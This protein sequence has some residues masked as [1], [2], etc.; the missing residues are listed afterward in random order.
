[1]AEPVPLKY[2]AFISYSHADTNWAK[3][4]QRGLEAFKIDKDLAGRE[5]ARGAIPESLRPIFRDREDFTAGEALPEQTLAALD[6]SSA[7][8]VVCSPDSNHSH[9]VNEE[10]RAFKSRHPSRS[11]IPLIVAG[12]PD[13]PM[14]ECFPPPLKFKFDTKG[15]VT[16]EKS[17]L[18]AADARDE[19]DGKDLALAKVIAGLLG[20]SPDEVFRRAERERRAAIRRRRRV[21]IGF[22]A[23]GWLL[24]AGL[25]A[26]INQNY[27]MEQW[28]WFS[29]IRPY[30]LSQFRPHVLTAEAEQALKP[31]DTFRECAKDCPE[32]VVLPAGMFVMGSPLDEKG[33]HESE[34]PQHEVTISKPFAVSKFEVTF[35]NWEACVSYG[36]CPVVGDSG[37]GRGQQPVI[38]LSWA[39]AQHYVAWLVRMTGK[40][41]R[42]LSE[43]EWEYA[44]RAG[45]QT[46]YSWG[47]ELGEGNANCKGCGSQWDDQQTAPVG[48]FA[49]NAFGLHDLHGNVFEWVEDVWHDGYQ[50]APSD[51]SVWIE[52]GDVG[53]RRLRGGSWDYPP[54]NLR[55]AARAWFHPDERDGSIGFRLARTLD[56]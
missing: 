13:D 3:W 49:A 23:L 17:E 38:N 30:M 8:I 21:Q 15:H 46:T 43:A 27:L 52:A 32:M 19:G 12:K 18:L 2:R 40:A 7:L 28:R 42:L 29:T 9:Y 39:D 1:M 25:V 4:L 48:S 11:L 35:D 44:A 20:L 16:K 26:W 24:L 54:E 33:R 14:Q 5:T 53:R 45:T 31:G 47:N 51:G 56:Q 50:G 37:F 6:A 41:Y 36:D 55:S 34:G 10:I 22:G